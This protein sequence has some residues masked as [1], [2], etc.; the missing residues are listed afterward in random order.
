MPFAEIDGNKLYYEDSG[1]DGTPVVLSHGGFLDHTMWEHTVAGLKDSYRLITWDERGHGMSEA[2]GPFDYWDAA[3]DA[4][5]LLDELGIDK[6]V[7]V[8]MS[9][10]GWLTQRVALG[11]PDR[12]LGIVLTATSM[13]LL[14]EQELEGYGALRD[15]WLAMGPVGDIAAA[16]LGVQFGGTDYDGTR[17]IGKWQSKP[18]AQWK[19]AWDSVL[20]GRDEIAGRFGEI[21]CP[22]LFVHG[23]V[24]QAFPVDFAHEM[25]GL[26]ADSRGVVVIEGAPHAIALTHPDEFNAALRDFLAGL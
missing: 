3:R 16:I 18:P 10:G 4:V 17:Y 21:A 24:D 19:P 13:H 8:G 23:T 9:Q 1:G 7:F 22:A 12:V 15:G 14:S 26:V 20:H 2:D 5:G 6:A 25:S 11:H